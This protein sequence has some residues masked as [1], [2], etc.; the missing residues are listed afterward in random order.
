MTMTHRFDLGSELHLFSIVLYIECHYDLMIGQ[1]TRCHYAQQIVL[2]SNKR[3]ELHH[4]RLNTRKL[5]KVETAENVIL[6]RLVSP[7][8]SQTRLQIK[9]ERSL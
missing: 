1:L 5:S 4:D 7:T 8:I 9:V 6:V 2:M 3:K